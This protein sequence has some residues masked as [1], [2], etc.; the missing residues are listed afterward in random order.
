MKS[1]HE[2]GFCVLSDSAGWWRVNTVSFAEPYSPLF[3]YSL[4]LLILIE[5]LLVPDEIKA[6]LSLKEWIQ[7][8]VLF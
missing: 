3:T 6:L 1:S 5:L 8:L 7:L 2:E 4:L